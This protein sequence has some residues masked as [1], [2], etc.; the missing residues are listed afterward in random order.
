M[1]ENDT[2]RE[3]VVKVKFERFYKKQK[4]ILT[5]KNELFWKKLRGRAKVD[6]EKIFIVFFFVNIKTKKTAKS[7]KKKLIEVK[8]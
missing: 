8:T 6:G 4:T 1:N 3:K 7:E 2:K 5:N